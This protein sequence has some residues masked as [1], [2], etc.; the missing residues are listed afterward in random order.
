[1]SQARRQPTSSLYTYG[2]YR[3]WQGDERWELI[4]GEAMLM[5]PAPRIQHQRVVGALYRQLAQFLEGNPCEALIAPFDVRLPKG[6]EADDAVDTV[7]QP[8]LVVVCDASKIDS[9]GVRGAPDLVVEVLSPATAGRDEILKR[10]LYERS[11]VREYWLIEP[12]TLSLRVY[13]ARDRRFGA[14]VSVR[15]FDFESMVL[16]GFRFDTRALRRV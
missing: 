5:S 15:N 12:E 13:Q 1:M 2:D 16:P 6:N 4:D 14:P 9:L 7:V 10:D 8:D 3:L 11:G